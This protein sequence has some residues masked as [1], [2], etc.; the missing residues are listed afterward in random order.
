MNS[1]NEV[2]EGGGHS[3][4]GQQSVSGYLQIYLLMV[5]VQIL[6]LQNVPIRGATEINLEEYV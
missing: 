1:G 5:K 3:S 4:A 2:G 6:E